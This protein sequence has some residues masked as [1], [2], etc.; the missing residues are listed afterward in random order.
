M[1]VSYSPD[2]RM[3]WQSDENRATLLWLLASPAIEFDDWDLRGLGATPGG[4]DEGWGGL[5]P[6]SGCCGESDGITLQS[7][8]RKVVLEENGKFHGDVGRDRSNAS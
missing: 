2:A 5:Q 1:A 3:R 4:N 7:T 8:V 6:S